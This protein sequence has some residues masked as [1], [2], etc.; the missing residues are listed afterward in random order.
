MEYFNQNQFGGKHYEMEIE[1][2]EFIMRNQIPF[3]EG[4]VIKYVARHRKK[5]G[6][7]DIK[8][9]MQ[10]LKFIARYEYNEKL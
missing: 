6:I 4:N 2:I 10:Y 5:N 1:P 3:A 9:A 7:E 8:K